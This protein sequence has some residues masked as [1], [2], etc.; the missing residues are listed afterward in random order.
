MD[1]P[2]GGERE[3]EE[4]L[5]RTI[6]NR[7]IC[8]SYQPKT[9]SEAGKNWASQSTE[10]LGRRQNCWSGERSPFLVS[11]RAT[12]RVSFHFSFLISARAAMTAVDKARLECL[13]TESVTPTV[14]SGDPPKRAGSPSSQRT[15][16]SGAERTCPAPLS[17]ALPSL[18]GF[19]DSH[20]PYHRSSSNSFSSE[21]K[22]LSCEHSPLVVSRS[23][24]KDPSTTD[25]SS[26]RR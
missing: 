5:Y 16:E 7:P 9:G 1:E 6:H 21:Q 4:E 23:S 8:R 26:L 24:H 17:A 19:L 22:S 25:R 10:R 13:K 15:A 3:I 2:R 12:T 20:H 14:R 18:L 11:H